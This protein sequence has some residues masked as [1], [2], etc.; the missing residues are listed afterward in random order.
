MAP[1]FSFLRGVLGTL[2]K[3]LGIDL[4]TSFTRILSPEKGVLVHEPSA[5]AINIRTQQLLAVGR[6]A[7]DMMGKNPPHIS[8]HHPLQKG[9]ISDFESTEKMLKVF[10]DQA[11]R[12]LASLMPRPRVVIGVPLETTEVERKAIEDAVF[13]AGAR[14]VNLVENPI[15][16]AI[17]ANMDISESSGI[18]VV[19]TGGGKTEIAVISLAGVVAWKSLPIAGDELNKNIVQYARDCFNLLI[20]ERHAE[21]VKREIGSVLETHE[22]PSMAMRGRDLLSGLPKEIRVNE[23]Q[24]HEAIQRSIAMIIENVKSTLEVTPPELVADIYERG[25]VLTGGGSL[26][27]GLAALL[28]SEAQIPVRVAE[29]PILCAVQG[30]GTLLG[31]ALLL[32]DI[33]LPSSSDTRMR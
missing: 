29:D 5:V 15:L 28:S 19:D 33:T 30:A 7:E 3:D 25:I 9:V 31:N 24:I 21:H 13:S 10:I 2:S 6:D 12:E 8:V 14:Q 4:G 18:L 27:R 32:K 20:G 16:C 1:Y 23:R 11:H 17:G 22:N 26:L